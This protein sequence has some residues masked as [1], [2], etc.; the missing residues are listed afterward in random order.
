MADTSTTNSWKLL[1]E[2]GRQALQD[3]KLQEAEQSFSASLQLAEDFPVGDPRLAATLNALARIYSL[4]RRYLAAAALLNRLLEVTERTLGPSHVQVAGVL[5]N[6]AEMYTHL[7]AAREEL[8][9]RER[10]LS[11]RADD[12]N[13]DATALQRLRDRVDE[14]RVTL[15]Q[16]A[17]VVSDDDSEFEALPIIRTAEYSAPVQTER[18][19]E[20]IVT[21]DAAVVQK[22]VAV[23][24]IETPAAVVRE[25]A[26]RMS[27]AT[28]QLSIAPWPG[29][30]ATGTT[31]TGGKTVEAHSAA[32]PAPE[33]AT[34]SSPTYEIIRVPAQ[35][36]MSFA[37]GMDHGFSDMGRDELQ[38]PAPRRFGN[39]SSLYSIA[40]GVLL[41]A[42][43]IA[44]RNYVK[45]SDDSSVSGGSVNLASVATPRPA[46]VTPVA[47]P[48]AVEPEPRTVERLIADH[49]AERE[50]KRAALETPNRDM[51]QERAPRI[52]SAA[53]IERTLR[54]LDG[55]AK[56]IDLRTK[57][58]ADSAS[59]LRLQAPTFKKV[60]VA[61]P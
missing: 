25:D 16:E 13:A 19:P 11:I 55:A 12:P 2:A 30:A 35:P 48:A 46:V 54:S 44:A 33:L 36:S 21:A 15:A 47:A 27:P 53:D 56:A 59:A 58:V 3:R 28:A 31:P 7:G 52:P 22:T 61:D 49:Q 29:T 26:F 6:L 10:V 60:K 57:A 9:L 23:V 50:A 43:L 1:Y 14:L 42:G 37:G 24:D 18:T 17:P 41:V 38:V 39:R 4:Q 40:A 45:G 8:E 5:T 20:P 51:S 34:P 32:T